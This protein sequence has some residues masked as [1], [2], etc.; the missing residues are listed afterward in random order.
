VIFYF[1]LTSLTGAAVS[2][3]SPLK[4]ILSALLRRSAELTAET[5]ARDCSS[6]PQ[7]GFGRTPMVSSRQDATI[8]K[9]TLLTG[10]NR[11]NEVF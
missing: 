4:I 9:K 1:T 6:L 10:E 2:I 8:A 5:F 3:S 7:Q 11:G